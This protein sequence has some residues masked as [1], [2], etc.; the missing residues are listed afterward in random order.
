MCKAARLRHDQSHPIPLPFIPSYTPSNPPHSPSSHP[1]T[2]HPF[3]HPFKPSSQ[4]FI[5]SHDLLV[6]SQNIPR[7]RNPTLR[8]PF[9]PST[10]LMA[11]QP[12]PRPISPSHK[13]SVHY[14]A[15]YDLPLCVTC[16]CT[17]AFISTPRQFAHDKLSVRRQKFQV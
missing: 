4:P 13:P 9:S 16:T 5:P 14:N 10:H 2:L 6:P 3:L 7:S 8:F 11:H 15:T 12:I 17:S 1:T